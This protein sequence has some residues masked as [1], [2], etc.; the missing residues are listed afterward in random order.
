MEISAALWA[1]RLWKDFT[2]FYDYKNSDATITKN[3]HRHQKLNIFN[4]SKTFR[5][6]PFVIFKNIAVRRKTGKA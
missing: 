2:F 4:Y 5:R 1:V 6:N 3:P